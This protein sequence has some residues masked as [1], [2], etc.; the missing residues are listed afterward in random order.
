MTQEE[1][2]MFLKRNGMNVENM[3]YNEVNFL[4]SVANK[5][6]EESYKECLLTFCKD[7]PIEKGESR[8]ERVLQ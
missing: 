2:I 8:N 5:T 1:T 3:S 7:R 4:I 6:A